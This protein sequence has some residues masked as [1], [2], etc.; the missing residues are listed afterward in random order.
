MNLVTVGNYA[1]LASAEL[2]A[3][4]LESTGIECVI[5]DENFAG[6]S[7]QMGTAL[8]GSGCRSQTKIWTSRALLS[9][10]AANRLRSKKPRRR[11]GWKT[12][13]SCAARNRSGRRSGRTA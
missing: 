4:I 13:A 9:K 1:D 11:R 2:A 7:W 12:P 8:Q 10:T 3:S 5:P 6:I